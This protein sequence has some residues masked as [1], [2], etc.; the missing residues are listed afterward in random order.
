VTGFI[1]S[2][3]KLLWSYG[4][5][6]KPKCQA[7]TLPNFL[8]HPNGL[9]WL[10]R[11]WAALARREVPAAHAAWA[12][13]RNRQHRSRSERVEACSREV[14]RTITHMMKPTAPQPQ[15]EGGGL[16]PRGEAH[17]NPHDA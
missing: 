16:Q 8:P 1:K 12:A 4:V 10:G 14:R 2:Q 3:S 11:H 6:A 7:L 15:R 9:S 13:E 5:A 17:D